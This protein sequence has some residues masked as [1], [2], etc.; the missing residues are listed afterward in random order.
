MNIRVTVISFFILLAV[1]L[2]AQNSSKYLVEISLSDNKKLNQLED[3]KI[4]VLHFTDE[5]L[6]TL[7]TQPKLTRVEELNIGFRTLDEKWANDR[8]Y[9]VS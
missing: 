6:I 7:L 9:I 1:N 5:S 8:Y 2:L 4:P 3:L